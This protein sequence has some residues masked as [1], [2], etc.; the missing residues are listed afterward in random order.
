MRFFDLMQYIGATV[1]GI[2][3]WKIIAELGNYIKSL[4]DNLAFSIMLTILI[5]SLFDYY[6]LFKPA[7][8]T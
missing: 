3:V 7:G 8:L 6:G 2:F 1:L 5:I 4:W